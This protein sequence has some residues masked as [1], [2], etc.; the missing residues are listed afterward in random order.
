MNKFILIFIMLV[1]LLIGPAAARDEGPMESG[2]LVSL[3][4]G[5][6]VNTDFFAAGRRV[7]IFGTV[8]GD[9]YA[10][11]GQVIVNGQINGDLLAAGGTIS[12]AGKITQDVRVAGGQITINGEIG[13]NLTVA[14]G[15]VELTDSAKIDGG[16]VAAGGSIG[17]AA[18]VGKDAKVAAGTVTVSGLIHE[19][20][21]LAAGEIRLTSR[22]AVNGDLSYWSKKAASIDPAAKVGGVITQKT[23]PEFPGPRAGTLLG[24]L[25]GFLLLAK[26]I[27]F[28]STLILGLLFIYLFPRYTQSTV[29]TLQKSPWASLGI[30]FVALVVIPV[31]A[32]ILAITVLGIPLALMVTALYLIAIY[33]ARVFAILW[34]GSALFERLGRPVREVWALVIG[35][36][37][38]FFLTLIPFLGGFI[39]LL[40]ILFG[41]GAALLAYRGLYLSAREKEML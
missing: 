19:N 29:S 31:T 4:A 2:E 21:D 41:L 16:L 18:P 11:G 1:S 37:L 3:P 15:N 23:M 32:G 39:S 8:N 20:L 33:L 17:L 34:A 7:E 24:V 27:S 13:R 22:A 9:V 28:V 12:I 26:L 6:V 30:G 35:L 14:G 36:M 40:V 25:L 10:A 38:Y 5:Q